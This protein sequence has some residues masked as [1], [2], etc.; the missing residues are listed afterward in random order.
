[1]YHRPASSQR[2]QRRDGLKQLGPGNASTTPATV[3][4]A[5]F[6]GST[7]LAPRTRAPINDATAAHRNAADVAGA[8]QR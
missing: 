4:L 2:D 6:V 1:M 5:A 3:A 8:E 7:S